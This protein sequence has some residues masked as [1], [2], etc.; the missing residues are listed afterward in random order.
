MGNEPK[1]ILLLT[2]VHPDFLPPVYAVARVL[3]DEGYQVH[4]LTFDSYVTS[5]APAERGIILESVGKHHDIGLPERL[6]IR[7]KYKKRARALVS[8]Q[9]VAVI[10]FCAFTYLCALR[11]KKTAPVIYHALEVADFL[12]DSLSRSPLSQINNLMAIKRL[13]RAQLVIT[14]SVQRS[15]WLAGR[16]R[17][18]HMPL[19]VMNT[20]WLPPS[21]E[22]DTSKRFYELVPKELHGKRTVLYTGAVNAHLCILELVQAF[23]ALNDPESALLITGVKDNAYCNEI[24]TT[25]AASACSDRIKLFPYIAREDMLTLQANADIGVSLAREYDDNLES[26]MMSPNKVGEYLYRGLYIVGVKTEYMRQ[27]GARGVAALADTP[28]ATHV[29]QA[30]K[31]ALETCTRTD[32]KSSIHK[33]VADEYNMQV[34]MK[35]V[36]TF[37]SKIVSAR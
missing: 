2:L 3:R 28:T 7:S 34:Q 24:K 1:R 6:L 26:K 25:V 29:Q 8:E 4:L 36:L 9:P 12:W 23:I 5:D 27:F 19:T 15:A 13:H 16:G 17:V 22:P 33:F 18:Q 30:L 32:V 14:P 35:P 37:L 11:V 10:A 20:A 21:P 31:E